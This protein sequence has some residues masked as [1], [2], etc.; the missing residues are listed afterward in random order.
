MRIFALLHRASVFFVIR[1]DAIIDLCPNHGSLLT[2]GSKLIELS[3]DFKRLQPLIFRRA[4]VP[5]PKSETVFMHVCS[6]SDVR[7]SWIHLS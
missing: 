4:F 1:T 7:C 5:K 2:F 3:K 6:D